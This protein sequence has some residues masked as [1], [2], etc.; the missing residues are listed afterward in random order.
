[1][2]YI[3]TRLLLLTFGLAFG[4]LGLHSDYKMCCSLTMILHCDALFH[5]NERL[6]KMSLLVKAET[7]HFVCG[8]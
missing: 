1:M 4:N 3:N 8:P 2:K 7:R 6:I 5:D